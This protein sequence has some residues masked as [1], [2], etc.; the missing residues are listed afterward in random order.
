MAQDSWPSPAHNARAVT[1]VEYE[2]LAARF[3]GDGVYGSPSDA[4]VVTAG[5]GL[6][7]SVRAEAFASLRGHLWYSGTTTVSLSIAANASGSTRIDWVVLRLDRTAWTVRA[8]IRQ[9]T[10][11]AGAP[12]LVQDQGSTGIYEIPLARVTI[13]NGAG[14]VSVTRAELYI[15]SRTRPCTSTTLPSHPAIGEEAYET[16]TGI[17]RLWTGS[18]WVIV[19][20]DS[21]VVNLGVGFSTWEADGGSVGRL[22]NGTVTLRIAKKLIGPRLEVTDTDGSKVATVPEPLRPLTLNHYFS[23]QFGGGHAARLE[24]RTSG[25]IWVRA[26]SEDVPTNNG[27]FATVTYVRW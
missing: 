1:D 4:A 17:L 14:A 9:G 26:L 2:Q 3:S 16:D 10:P 22:R 8:V 25:D 21:G 7:A 20:Q 24:V 5:V 23:C 13:L 11:G 6:T 18:S 27:L 15:G 12:A 19:F